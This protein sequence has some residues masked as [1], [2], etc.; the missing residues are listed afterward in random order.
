MVRSW[1]LIHATWVTQP[2]DCT[3]SFLDEVMFIQLLNL[4]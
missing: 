1:V 2:N 4:V 3:I